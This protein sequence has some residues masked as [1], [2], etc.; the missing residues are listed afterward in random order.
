MSKQEERAKRSAAL[1]NQAEDYPAKYEGK[2]PLQVK[3]LMKVNS[4]LPWATH[5][6]AMKNEIYYV[7]VNS[8]G[9]VTALLHSG[10]ELGIKSHE[11]EVVAWH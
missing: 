10:E 5:I 6:M 3:M 9:A 1:T 8:H 4:D 2:V 11:F 7:H